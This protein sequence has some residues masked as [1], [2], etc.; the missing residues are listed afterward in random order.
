LRVVLIEL[1]Q[2]NI[3]DHIN[4]QIARAEQIFLP[5]SR[6]WPGPC[7]VRPAWTQHLRVRTAL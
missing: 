4:G 6:R 2:R 3:A 1:P 7:A 5:T